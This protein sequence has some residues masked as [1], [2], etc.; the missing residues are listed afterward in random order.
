MPSKPRNALQAPISRAG[1]WLT[2]SVSVGAALATILASAHSCGVIGDASASRRTFAALSVHWVGVTPAT[3]S[4]RAIGDTVRLLA[5]VTDSRG[6][7]LVGAWLE[8]ESKDT[9]VAVVDSTGVVVARAPGSTLIGVRAGEKLATSRIVVAPRVASIA[10]DSVAPIPEGGSRKVN[11]AGLDRRG[12]L[13]PGRRLRWSSSDSSIVRVDSTGQVRAI[14]SGEANVVVQLDSLVARTTI[15]VTPVPFRIIAVEGDSQVAMT[16]ELLA[17]HVVVRVDSRRG[18][19]LAGVPVRFTLRHGGSLK[20]PVAESDSAGLVRAQWTLGG[21]PG[22]QQLL[23]E[24]DGLAEGMMLRAEA[25]PRLD[26]VRI[27][28]SE[29]DSGPAGGAVPLP[30]TA[31]VTDADGRLLPG[32]PVAWQA[33]DS[34]SIVARSPRTDSLGESHASWALGPRA[35]RQRARVLVGGGRVVPPV[36]ITARALAGAPA[37]LVGGNGHGQRAAAGMPLKRPIEVRVID[38]A[39][40]GIPGVRVIANVSSGIAGDTLLVTDSTGTARFH[41]TLG[42]KTGPQQ[43]TFRSGSLPRITATVYAMPGAPASIQFVSSVASGTRGKVLP[44]L[45]L[46]ITDAHGNR[47]MDRQ[48]TFTASSGSATPSQAMPASDGVLTTSWKLGSKRGKQTL[49]AAV[50]GTAVRTEMVVNVR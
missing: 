37:F 1:R 43:V 5:S 13:V 16:G 17:R 14:G 36:T 25:E 34:G 48:V 42:P 27:T 29:A 2:A 6:T 45:K 15:R 22:E 28:V 21:Q 41:W 19:P 20:V 30:V 10:L 35:G 32:V 44:R 8:W 26:N 40:N 12:H 4:L 39:R 7:A 46:I 47:V 23:V 49:V 33:L 31:R 24:A 50:R 38:Q 3:D 11:A 9:A 18:I